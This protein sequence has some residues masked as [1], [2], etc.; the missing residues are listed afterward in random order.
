M[1]MKQ[2][3]VIHT[4]YKKVE[5][6]PYHRGM[7][8]EDCELEFFKEYEDGLKDIEQASHLIVLSWLDKADRDVLQ[9]HNPHGTEI[10]GIFVT[11]TQN[12]PNPIGVT[13]AKL[14]E[15]RGN[16]LKVTGID[17]LDGTPLLDIKPYFA[18]NDAIQDARIEWFEKAILFGNLP[19]PR[20]S[21]GPPLSVLHH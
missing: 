5:D 21:R 2:I 17:A 12:R 13:M 20:H 11:R 7:A 10:Y 4:P 1:E 9:E 15:R 6:V 14:L 19:S 18:G 8:E 16:I 3:G